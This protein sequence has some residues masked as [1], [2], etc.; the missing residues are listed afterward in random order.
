MSDSAP[1]PS[2]E[3]PAETPASAATSAAAPASVP[4]LNPRV[5]QSHAYE[6]PFEAKYRH[7]YDI[8]E[9]QYA[10]SP[11][12]AR[13]LAT[14]VGSGGFHK[15][16]SPDAEHQ[17]L[18]QAVA[19]Y[20]GSRAENVLLT[21]ASDSALKLI[22]DTFCH[23][24]SKV[25]IPTP[26]YPHFLNFLSVVP[27]EHADNFLWKGDTESLTL[28][29]ESAPYDICYLCNPNMPIGFVLSAADIDSW[30]RAHPRTLFI[31]DEAYFEYGNGQSSVSLACSRENVVVTRTFSKAFG[32][33]ALRIGYLIATPRNLGLLGVA[34]NGKNVTRLAKAAALAALGDLEWY[35]AEVSRLIANREYLKAALESSLTTDSFVYAGSVQYG[36]FFSLFS[37]DSARL[38][39]IFKANGLLIRDKHADIPH[40]VRLTL[41]TK[42]QLDEVLG[43][44]HLVNTYY[45]GQATKGKKVFIDLDN[46]LRDGSHPSSKYSPQAAP[47]IRNLGACGSVAYITTNNCCQ[48]PDEIQ[49]GLRK[50]GADLPLDR[51]RTPLV[52]AKRVLRGRRVHVVGSPA[53]VSW[54]TTDL[55]VT[56][57]APEAVL[58]SNM[59]H[60]SLAGGLVTLCRCIRSCSQLYVVEDPLVCRLRDCGDTYHFVDE[61]T[62]IPDLGGFLAMLAPLL[63]GKTVTV[64]GK[65]GLEIVSDVLSGVKDPAQEIVVVGDGESDVRFAETI[66]CPFVGV[67]PVDAAVL[68]PVQTVPTSLDELV[69]VTALGST[70]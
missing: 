48:T 66:G 24:T 47:L 3:A 14:A 2:V 11:A 44:V 57:D 18:V 46:T 29:L 25:L 15:Y 58:I 7:R 59:F 42:E 1:P 55:V 69:A 62:P 33:A 56:A 10:P 35:T 41:G 4:R 17:A 43:L 19:K 52:A 27:H 31:V 67:C 8:I 49:E 61:D 22:C 60:A 26:T 53:V 16:P 9:N 70:A 54:L 13:A 65:P 12:V 39:Q 45:A 37:R 30:S 28:R 20:V 50:A 32:L 6:L 21:C 23:E 34:H 51:I 68:S 64:L 5:A 40:S 38:T 63:K 36:N